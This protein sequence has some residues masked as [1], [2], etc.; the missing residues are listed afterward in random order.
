MKNL[1]QTKALEKL[2]ETGDPI[3]IVAAV[4]ESEVIANYCEE[5]NIK[6]SAICDNIKEKSYRKFCG[7]NVVHTPELPTKFSKARFIIVS[8]HIQDCIEQLVSLGYEEFYSPIDFLNIKNIELKSSYASSDYLK[9]RIDVCKKSHQIFL[10]GDNK[11]YLRSIDIMV[12]TRC[13]LKCESCSNLMQYYDNPQNTEAKNILDSIDIISENVD[14]I[15]EFRLIGGEPLMNKSWDDIA[16]GIS[17]KHNDKQIFIYTNG[18]IAPKDEK[19]KKI[20]GRKINFIITE[21]GHLSKNL[22]KLQ[23]QLKKFKINYL[24]SPADHWVDCSSIKH[25]NRS[26]EDLKLVFKQCCVKY[27]YTLLDGKLYRC[28]FIANAAKLNAIPDNSYN[29]VNLLSGNTK[30]K[31]EIK[32]LVN[33]AKFF[34]G[35]NFCVGRPYDGTSKVGYDGKGMIK[36]GIQTPSILSYKKYN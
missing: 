23:D 12:T 31:D 18:T 8:Q 33:V 10:N 28:P 9:A 14:E 2:K 17:N 3:I 20:E 25:H 24:S 34:P 22:K 13:S 7:Y 11:I 29:Y 26:V 30:I 1:I 35:C 4:P 15:A 5:N 32:R 27:I 19:L 21:Y 6:I 16:I 36:A